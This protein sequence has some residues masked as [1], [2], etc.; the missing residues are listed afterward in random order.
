[1]S[2]PLTVLKYDLEISGFGS[3]ALGHVCLLNLS[4]QTYPGSNGLETKGWPTW[5]VPVMRWCKEQGG[6]TGYAH[7]ASGL[8]IDEKA[9][10][11][12]LMRRLDASGDG[13]LSREEIGDALLPEA[14]EKIDADAGGGLSL[15]ELIASHARAAEQLPNLAIPEM[16][17]VGAMELPVSVAE[18]VCDF[19]SAMDTR[20]IQEWN[21][22]Y[23]VLNC[24][25]PL[26]ASGETDFPCMSSRSVGQGR[27]YVR[28]G[29]GG[30]GR[31]RG[32]V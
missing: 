16:N 24:G 21:T 1:M 10:S 11:Q 9:A 27:V 30:E 32:L 3:Q 12:R 28:L 20:R 15:A 5:T 26:K 19:I 8:W 29:A 25:F 4:D 14:F 2:E 17:G 13:E 18:G 31:L 6:V 23:H 22:W 7:S